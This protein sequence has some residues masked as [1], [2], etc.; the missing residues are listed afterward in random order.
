MSNCLTITPG[1]KL[2]QIRSLSIALI[3][4]WLE[5]G[6]FLETINEALIFKWRFGAILATVNSSF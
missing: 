1:C 6:Q 3:F 5:Q 2:F 4:K